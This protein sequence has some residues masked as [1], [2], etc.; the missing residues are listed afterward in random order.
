MTPSE[1][2]E[3]WNGKGYD[4]DGSYGLQCVDGFKIFCRETIGKYWATPNGYADG[5]WYN[6]AEYTKYFEP[7]PVGQFRDGDWVIWARGSK[8]HPNS[9]IAMY[10]QNFEFGMNQGGDRLFCLKR[11]DFSDALGAL[12]WRGWERTMVIGIG[13]QEKTVNGVTAVIYRGSKAKGYS[14]HMIPAGDAYNSLADITEIDSDKLDII[15]KMNANFFQMNKADYGCHYGAEQDSLVN[16]YHQEPKGA[17]VLAMW[18]DH[19]GNVGVCDQSDYWLTVNDVQMA[20]APYEMRKHLGDDTVLWSRNLGDMDDVKALRSVALKFA[21]GDWALAVFKTELYP[22]DILTYF[23][24]FDELI[25]E[26]ALFDGG[27]SSQ[28][29]YWD[30][31]T[32]KKAVYTGRKIP[33]VLA[34]AKPRGQVP[35]ESPKEPEKPEEPSKEKEYFETL[36]EIYGMCKEIMSMIEGVTENE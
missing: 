7:I 3:Q 23:D 36:S 19:D 10:F 17:G 13:Y 29:L 33:N 28:L 6:R 16:G 2:I 34:I 27:G 22:R 24:A 18:V 15:A 11:T 12:R 4:L 8:S 21:N 20:C 14:L 35:Q 5:Y 25:I 1:F 32:M 9:H 30:G 26:I 31:E